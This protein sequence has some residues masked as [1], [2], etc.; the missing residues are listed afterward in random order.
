MTSE[1]RVR[2]A[3]GAK[4]RKQPRDRHGRWVTANYIFVDESG[5]MGYDF[6]G[7]SSYD[8]M[9]SVIVT[10]RILDL[11]AIEK[12]HEKNTN[13]SVPPTP[14]ELKYR[15]SSPEVRRAVLEEIAGLQ[16]FIY[17][18]VVHKSDKPEGGRI[19]GKLYRDTTAAVLEEAVKNID[20]PIAVIYDEH[21]SLDKGGFD[22]RIAEEKVKEKLWYAEQKNSKKEAGLQVHDFVIGSTWD[23]YN[24]GEKGGKKEPF[25][26][27]EH[28]IIVK[29]KP[30]RRK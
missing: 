6:E 9:M 11:R 18:E 16:P 25:D 26:V 5:D 12:H 14:G 1:D 15:T 4:A 20:W 27:I 13:P 28:L 24:R 21:T 7:G 17:A 22:K 19:G 29:E 3:Q 23:R 30:E 10:D 8:F 2:Y